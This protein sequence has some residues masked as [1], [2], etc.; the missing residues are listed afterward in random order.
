[1]GGRAAARGTGRAS[2]GTATVE[3]ILPCPAAALGLLPF[4]GHSCRRPDLALRRVTFTFHVCPDGGHAP[5]L[6]KRSPTDRLRILAVFSLPSGTTALALRRER[7]ALTRLLERVGG[8]IELRILQYGTTRQTFRQACTDPSG[9]GVVH[10]SGHGEAA[11]II[12]ETPDSAPDPV[13][14][15]DL[16]GLM[17]P[18]RDAVNLVTL[19]CASARGGQHWIGCGLPG[20]DRRRQDDLCARTRGRQRRRVRDGGVAFHACDGGGPRRRARRLRRDHGRAAP[21]A[22]LRAAISSDGFGTVVSA[23]EDGAAAPAC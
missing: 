1:M 20:D 14:V 19:S 9:W 13:S 18:L 10:V 12:L 23:L 6:A 15:A 16:V 21:G 11:G 8:D 17:L 3:V 5:P 2:R 7:V 22:G 4:R